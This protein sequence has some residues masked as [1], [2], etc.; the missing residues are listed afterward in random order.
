[1]TLKGAAATPAARRPFRLSEGCAAVAGLV[2]PGRGRRPVIVGH[3]GDGQ[4]DALMSARY[5]RICLALFPSFPR[6]WVNRGE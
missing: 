4:P 2:R 5:A 3:P 6:S 1:M